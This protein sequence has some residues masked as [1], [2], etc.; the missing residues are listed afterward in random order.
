MALAK[1]SRGSGGPKGVLI[2]SAAIEQHGKARVIGTVKH[3]IID[4]SRAGVLLSF[5]WMR[6]SGIIQRTSSRAT[7]D[8][9]FRPA[10]QGYRMPL[11]PALSLDLNRRLINNHLVPVPGA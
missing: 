8:H 7:V 5:A 6:A 11:K 2:I 10:C 1:S 4:P 3:G 9:L